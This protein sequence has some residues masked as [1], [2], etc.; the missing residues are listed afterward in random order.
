MIQ[1]REELFYKKYNSYDLRT[2]ELPLGS[3]PEAFQ[4]G[5]RYSIC[6]KSLDSNL[7]IPRGLIVELGCASGDRLVY[8]R[9]KYGFAEGLGVDLAYDEP[10]NF[11]GCSFVNVN[12][13][14]PWF[15]PSGG[16]DCLVAMM[17]FEHLFD[18]WF[19]FAEVKRVLSPGGRAYVN[20]P[21]VTSV[22]N[23]VRLLLG[24]IPVTSVPYSRW[25]NEGHWDGFHLHYFT[26]RSIYDLVESSGLKISSVSA[27]GRMS[28]LK[29]IFPSFLC[30]ELSFELMH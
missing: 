1:S 22:K 20:L 2:L 29:S 6:S 15:L 12:L 9:S 24:C 30:N 8:L 7:Q 23:R 21:L 27:V 3:V 5:G 18:P 26:I 19:C 16:V 17:L 14:S 10:V 28:Q 4:K 11:S 25:K 13:N